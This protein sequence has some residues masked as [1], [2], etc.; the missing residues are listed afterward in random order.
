GRENLGPGRDLGKAPAFLVQLLALPVPVFSR[1]KKAVVEPE[2]QR[3]EKT[4]RPDPCHLAP[5]T[6]PHSARSLPDN[7]NTGKIGKGTEPS[8]QYHLIQIGAVMADQKRL[9][10]DSPISPA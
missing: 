6:P 4:Q 2:C 9:H 1:E 8:R 5:G 7:D 10:R 3:V